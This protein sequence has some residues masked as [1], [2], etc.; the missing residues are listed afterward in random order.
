[1]QPE[2]NTS[3][4]MRS[5]PGE[6]E[7]DHVKRA[8]SPAGSASEGPANAPKNEKEADGAQSDVAK[9][10]SRSKHASVS[11]LPE[12]QPSE[13]VTAYAQPTMHAQIRNAEKVS[14]TLPAHSRYISNEISLS[15]PSADD[16]DANGTT[17][18]T[19]TRATSEETEP[20][21]QELPT[22]NRQSWFIPYG[23]DE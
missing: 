1:M 15:S 16:D 12:K 21:N 10:A 19:T 2:K 13:H 17:G 9:H 3:G 11:L 23:P 8:T 14:A 20:P 5:A 18:S 4:T 6:R 7:N 22:Q